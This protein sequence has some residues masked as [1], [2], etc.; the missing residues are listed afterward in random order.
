LKGAAA[1]ISFTSAR[2]CRAGRR[3]TSMSW[4]AGSRISISEKHQKLRC[5]PGRSSR[6]AAISRLTAG[7]FFALT[8]IFCPHIAFA[9]LSL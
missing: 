4:L 7:S 6:R 5:P 1:A 2:R 9:V 8:I 3:P